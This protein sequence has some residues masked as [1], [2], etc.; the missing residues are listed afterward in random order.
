MFQ[1]PKLTDAGRA[2]YY[3]NLAGTQIVFT[4]IKLGSGYLTGPI[5]SMT[6]LVTPVVTIDAAAK[7]V[8]EQYAEISGHFSNADLAAG[9][10]WREIGI[11][12][13]DPADPD[14]RAADILYCYQNAYET[15]DFIP[16][17]SVETVEK[18]I[19]VPVIV[20]DAAAVSCVLSASLIL[21]TLEDL[22]N[23]NT[24]MSAHENLLEKFGDKIKDDL[25]R[26][27]ISGTVTTALTTRAGETITTRNGTEILAIKNNI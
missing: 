11:F 13:A 14:N 15:A 9:F 19:T 1:A 21:A 20:G 2:L 8:S 16:V 4:S 10:Y 5:A 3:D 6:N 24:S 12:A 17:A 23:H 26:K 7:S 25:I 22:N 18:A 27:I